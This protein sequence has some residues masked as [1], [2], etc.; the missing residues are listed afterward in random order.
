MECWAAFECGSSSVAGVGATCAAC[1][2]SI[3]GDT[4]S[5]GFIELEKEFRETWQGYDPSRHTRFLDRGSSSGRVE[6][7]TRLLCVELE[8]YYKP[9]TLVTHGLRECEEG[10]TSEDERVKPCVHLFL[11]RFPEL[12]QHFDC[13]TRLIVL[14]YALR[15]HYSNSPPNIESYI[16]LF[17]SPQDQDRLIDLLDAT[18]GRLR[19]VRSDPAVPVGH[20]DSTVVEA[21]P[22]SAI[23]LPPLP[24]NL[25]CFLLCRLVGHGGMGYV[26]NATDLRST[27]NVAVKVMR[28]I[29]SWSIYRF[30]EE[31]TWLSQ[32]NHPNLVRL[33][34]AFSEGD[35]RYFSM[36]LVTG[37][38]IRD[39]YCKASAKGS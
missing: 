7:L 19:A 29:D 23:T 39:W 37:K 13:L 35:V 14:E 6:L 32:L 9:P 11:L 33:Y 34:D 4:V 18:D 20:T 28:R 2:M 8:Y 17:D 21:E 5:I 27:A 1:G 15:I 12:A 24:H 26:Y 25:G 3:G 30:N 10:T 38:T 36:E 16:D 31:F 22:S